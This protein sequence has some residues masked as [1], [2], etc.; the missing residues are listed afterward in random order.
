M[1]RSPEPASKENRQGLRSPYAQ[2]SP[3]ASGSSA[4]GLSSGIAYGSPPCGSIRSSLPSRVSSFWPLPWGR[5]RPSVAEPDVEVAVGA[6]RDGA[7]VVVGLGLLLGQDGAPGVLLDRAVL[8]GE[9]VDGAGAREVGV[10]DVEVREP[11]VEGQAEQA[12]F[13]VGGGLVGDVEH[14][15]AESVVVEDPDG[16]GAFGDPDRVLR[17][18]GTGRRVLGPGHLGQ[19]DLRRGAGGVGLVGGRRGQ[20]QGS[21]ETHCCEDRRH[22]GA[23]VHHGLPEAVSGGSAPDCPVRTWGRPGRPTTGVGGVVG[24]RRE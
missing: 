23:R 13:A 9:L 19:R 22:S 1:S 18:G 4:K 15:F 17:A 16:A 5:R 10:G 7:A 2:I 24:H 8:D 12:T 11:L 14:G 20:G 6:E 3:L 21:Y